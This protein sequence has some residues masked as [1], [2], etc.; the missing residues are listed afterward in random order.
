[1][2][3]RIEILGKQ[4]QKKKERIIIRIVITLTIIEFRI[5]IYF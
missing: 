1:M 2:L 4:Y 3:P 5:N